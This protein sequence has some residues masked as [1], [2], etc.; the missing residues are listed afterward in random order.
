[1]RDERVAVG[2]VGVPGELKAGGV[3][4][5]KRRVGDGEEREAVVEELERGRWMSSR[6]R[7][8]WGPADRSRRGRVIRKRWSSWI[9]FLCSNMVGVSVGISDPS[10]RRKTMREAKE[11]PLPP[12]SFFLFI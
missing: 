5:G 2:R 8:W 3:E 4:G 9:F 11:L 12:P 1:L 7:G 10:K 6:R